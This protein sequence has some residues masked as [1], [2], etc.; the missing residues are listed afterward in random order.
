MV[1][2]YIYPLQEKKRRAAEKSKEAG[3]SSEDASNTKEEQAT[4]QYSEDATDTKGG[5]QERVI[6]LRPLNMEDFRQAKN[7]VLSLSLSPCQFHQRYQ[8]LFNGFAA[9]LW[10]EQNSHNVVILRSLNLFSCYLYVGVMCR[11]QRALHLRD[12]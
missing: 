9:S 12:Q 10:L 8:H 3:Q 7:Q 6:T 4:G 5:K 2:N 11:S 1:M